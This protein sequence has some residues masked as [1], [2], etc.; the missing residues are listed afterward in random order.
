MQGIGNVTETWTFVNTHL[1]NN[2][3]QGI[4]KGVIMTDDGNAVATSTELGR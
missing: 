4:G 1:S 2:I 3:I